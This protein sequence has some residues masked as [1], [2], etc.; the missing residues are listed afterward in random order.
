M[1]LII[2]IDIEFGAPLK[3]LFYFYYIFQ[4]QDR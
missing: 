1:K 4:V 2:N 3:I